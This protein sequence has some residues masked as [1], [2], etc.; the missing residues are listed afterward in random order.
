MAATD[1]GA[2]IRRFH[3]APDAPIR[4]VCFAHAGGSAAYFFPVSRVLSPQL[5]VLAVQY[6][7]RH[8]RRSESAFDD[9]GPLADA[10]VDQL[11]EWAD[12]PLAFFGHSLGATVAFEVARRLEERGTPL[13][14]LFVSGRRAPSRHKMQWVHQGD[15]DELIEEIIALDGTDASMLRDPELVRMILPAFRADLKAAETYRFRPGPMLSC[16]VFALV[17]DND[18]QVTAAEADSWRDHTTAEFELHVYPGG[19]FYL[20]QHA[21][22]VLELIRH[23]VDGAPARA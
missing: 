7:G 11:T 19:H 3:P 13:V 9:V 21:G 22:D 6:P 20:N 15:D 23:R 4:L 14:S 16:P 18:P 8:D 10:V 17:G 5:D 1:N 12:R 2:W